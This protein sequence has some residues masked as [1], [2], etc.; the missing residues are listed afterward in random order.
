MIVL[1]RIHPFTLLRRATT[2]KI[3]TFGRSRPSRPR[4]A[5][6]IVWALCLSLLAALWQPT[7]VAAGFSDAEVAEITR[8]ME[9]G[10]ELCSTVAAT[11]QIDCYRRVYERAAQDL[12]GQRLQADAQK[13]MRRT[14]VELKRLARALADPA[15]PKIEVAGKSVA[16]IRA[17]AL[18][19]ATAQ[20][21]RILQE[22]ETYLLRG[23]RQAALHYQQIASVVNSSKVLLRST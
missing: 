7:P 16:A 8:R 15:A 2:Q 11:Y 6:R 9:G 23:N 19:Q 3:Q 4:G 22:T 10:F 13:A 1:S 14:A 18:P 5:G 20:A 17:D 12:K 21:R